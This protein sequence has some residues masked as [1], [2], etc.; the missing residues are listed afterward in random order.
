MT[1]DQLADILQAAMRY[2]RSDIEATEYEAAK[3][4]GAG[5]RR[6]RAERQRQYL[7][8]LVRDHDKATHDTIP[9]QSAQ[10]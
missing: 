8:N 5:E 2:A 3:L 6:H 10:V 9:F 1:I 4:P 7:L